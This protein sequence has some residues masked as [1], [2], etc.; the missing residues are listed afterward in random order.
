MKRG[1]AGSLVGI[2]GYYFQLPSSVII[3]RKHSV[4]WRAVLAAMYSAS[5]VLIAIVD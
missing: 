2:G 1:V 5:H 4:F 3:L